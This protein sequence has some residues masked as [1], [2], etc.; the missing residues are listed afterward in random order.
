M[1]MGGLWGAN[2]ATRISRRAPRGSVAS[3]GVAWGRRACVTIGWGFGYEL[4]IGTENPRRDSLVMKRRV[5]LAFLWPYTSWTAGSLAAMIMGLHPVVG[6]AAGAIAS[7]M[8]AASLVRVGSS[9]RRSSSPT[10]NEANPA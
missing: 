10:A 6:P 5:L 9:S 4:A 7:I 8:Y 2:L 3:V 1:G